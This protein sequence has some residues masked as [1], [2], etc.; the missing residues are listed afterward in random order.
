MWQPVKWISYRTRK[1]WIRSNGKDPR[2]INFFDPDFWAK[3]AFRMRG[4][5]TLLGS[6]LLGILALAALYM[7]Y[8]YT[9]VC[10]P[11]SRMSVLLSAVLG[12]PGV[13]LLVLLN[14]I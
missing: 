12:V 7:L 11:I 1:S 9:G 14:L 2:G 13:T 8:P 10:V 6:A 3:E 5:K 4:I